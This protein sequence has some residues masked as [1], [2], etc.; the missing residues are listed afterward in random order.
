MTFRQ[1]YHVEGKLISLER[2]VQPLGRCHLSPRGDLPLV[3]RPK[4]PDR[5]LYSVVKSVA[6]LQSEFSPL[7]Q[8]ILMSLNN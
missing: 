8:V 7:A 3:K 5:S 2:Q 1:G 4:A 6:V